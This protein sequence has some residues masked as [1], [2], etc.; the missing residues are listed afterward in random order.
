[1][2]WLVGLLALFG[3]V[4]VVL[5]EVARSAESGADGVGAALTTLEGGGAPTSTRAS[6]D[7]P[8]SFPSGPSPLFQRTA[9][10]SESDDVENAFEPGEFLPG[11]RVPTGGLTVD[12]W[13]N[14][15]TVERFLADDGDL[16]RVERFREYAVERFPPNL[17]PDFTETIPF[18]AQFEAL[19]NEELENKYV[20]LRLSL[21][22][23]GARARGAV[24]RYQRDLAAEVERRYAAYRRKHRMRSTTH[25]D[26]LKAAKRQLLQ[27]LRAAS[28][29][30]LQSIRRYEQEALDRLDRAREWRRRQNRSGPG[31]FETDI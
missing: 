14:E 12:E 20:E 15:H 1:M 9:L 25:A 13:L 10:N 18:A 6:H 31:I 29:D 21:R 8:A 16:L 27:S 5:K 23:D 26:E 11:T 28:H 30:S 3:V 4:G 22:S 7:W 2:S 24:L 19:A 17:T